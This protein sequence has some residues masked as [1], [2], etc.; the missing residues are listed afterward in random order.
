MNISAQYVPPPCKTMMPRTAQP[1][2]GALGGVDPWAIANGLVKAAMPSQTVAMINASPLNA[3]QKKMLRDEP[4]SFFVVMADFGHDV[5]LEF[6]QRM[7]G[8]GRSSRTY[9]IGGRSVK[10]APKK[11][12]TPMELAAWFLT[13]CHKQPVDAV[14]ISATLVWELGFEA[15]LNMSMAAI[16]NTVQQTRAAINNAMKMARNAGASAQ[17]VLQA[18]IKAA[19]KAAKKALSFTPF[20]MLGEPG[21]SAGAGGA[22]VVVGGAGGGGA[23]TGTAGTI[24]SLTKLAIVLAPILVPRMLDM[25][26]GKSP[27][28][29]DAEQKQA[30]AAGV[31]MAQ[32]AEAQVPL[33]LRE[34]VNKATSGKV[35]GM[36]PALA[37]GLGAVGVAGAIFGVVKLAQRR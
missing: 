11:S 26:E 31:A 19:Q 16:N 1:G 32:Q 29:P 2:L 17:K 8:R 20:G 18:G 35:L 5:F 37:Y 12:S 7:I 34:E 23:A 28:A 25:M 22:M 3:K 6:L 27:S 24:D 21:S 9:T 36:P 14:K 13:V 33:A 4:L 15:P 10:V 30:A